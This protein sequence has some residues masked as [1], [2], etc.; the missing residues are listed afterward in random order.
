[1]GLGGPGAMK[2]NRKTAA[3]DKRRN[4]ECNFGISKCCTCLLLCS[5]TG[6]WVREGTQLRSTF[7]GSTFTWEKFSFASRYLMESKYAN[8]RL[9]LPPWRQGGMSFSRQ[10][11]VKERSELF[12][13]QFI[14]LEKW[15]SRFPIEESSTG[16]HAMNERTVS[17]DF[18]FQL[19][20]R[21][22]VVGESAFWCLLEFTR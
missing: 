18:D 9:L 14:K 21:Q 11:N 2:H 3:S 7:H 22:L 10:W 19:K 20:I 17:W 4:Y 16:S 15:Q 5:R 8:T 6:G 13:N 1:M 12:P